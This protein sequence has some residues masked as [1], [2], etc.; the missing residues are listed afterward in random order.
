[1]FFFWE[2]CSV[3][4][5]P[6]LDKCGKCFS[7]DDPARIPVGSDKSCPQSFVDANGDPIDGGGVSAGV[8]V[9]IIIAS[10]SIVGL[11]VY[12]YMRQQQVLN[13]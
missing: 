6:G 9:A 1:M 11:G 8:V 4:G 7:E 13:L 12:F 3:C 5:G 10:V 2:F